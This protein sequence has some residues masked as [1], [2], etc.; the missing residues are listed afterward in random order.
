MFEDEQNRSIAMKGRGATVNP[1]DR[2]SKNVYVALP[3]EISEVGPKT[4]VQLEEVKS[5]LSKN[6]SPDLPFTYGLNPYRGCEHGCVYC[7]ARP[8]HEYLGMSLGLDF[9]TKLI[10]KRNIAEILRKELSSKN[11]V[12]EAITMSGVT[13]CYQPIERE[14]Q[15]SRK[16]L[17]VF[18]E[19][20]NPVVIITKNSLVRRDLD[21]LIELNY[22][23]AVAVFV[24][25]TSLDTDLALRLEPRASAPAQRFK[26]VADLAQA[27][28]P[29]GVMTA[30]I[31]P[32][33]TDAEIPKLLEA[34][35]DAGAR[36]AGYTMVRL[37][38]RVDEL[39]KHWLEAHYP[40]K[41]D[42]VLALIRE[43]RGGE[44]KDSRF[45]SRMRGEG[46]YAE[47]I[48]KLF[49]VYKRKFGLADK[50]LE[51][52]TAHFVRPERPKGPENQ[53]SLF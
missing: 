52:S 37:P 5:A 51:L 11:W 40:E 16:C 29:V 24:S 31:I 7:Y 13:D 34:A 47:Q 21:L 50:K 14:Y 28:I 32:G 6:D 25:I 8:T 18:L 53:M 12:P 26:L 2:F 48:S 44:L 1:T 36:Y 43:V 19:T 30:P 20:K 38:Y 22:F 39:F 3:E 49:K 41:K 17:E 46:V 10:A 45:G 15:L 35:K 4:S 9:E 23:N 33:L 42:R 27:G